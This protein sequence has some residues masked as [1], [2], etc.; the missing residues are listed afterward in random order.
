MGSGRFRKRRYSARRVSRRFAHTMITR[1]MA[2]NSDAA[3][4]RRHSDVAST[5][6]RLAHGLRTEGAGPARET[7]AIA[8]GVFIGCQPFYGFHLLLCWGVG[9][10]FGLNRLKLYLAANISNPLVAPFLLFT[11]LQTGSWL[12]RGALHSL[13]LEAA[14]SA[15]VAS[16]SID[17]LLGSLVIG[18]VL[19]AAAGWATY[20]TI[21]GTAAR[22]DPFVDL[23]RRASDRFVSMSITAWEFARGKLRR[24]PVYRAAVY[25]GLLL[26]SH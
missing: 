15:G 7:A 20:A 25:D 4:A 1:R 26:G 13:T 8:C 18:A 17:L 9:W 6:R 12:R 11:E 3:A 10:I 5:L 14:R 16:L 21:G 23:V 24:D 19:A 22:T 2:Q